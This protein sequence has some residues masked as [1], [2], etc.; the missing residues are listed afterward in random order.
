MPGSIPQSFI[1][2]LITR[3]D[4]VELIDSHVPLTKKGKE[5]MACC[6]FHNEKTPSFTVSPD[7][8][9]Y[10]CFG[11]GAHGTAVGFLMEFDRLNFVEAVEE[12]AQRAGLNVPRDTT[13]GFKD[14][15]RELST[16]LERAG[17]YYQKMLRQHRKPVEYLKARG[18]S[19]EIAT[20]FGLGFAPEGFDNLLRQ[21]RGTGTEEQLIKAGLI[22]RNDKGNCFDRFRNRIVFPIKNQRGRIIGFGGRVLDDEQPKYLN[23][24]ETPLFH[25][26]Q[27]LYGLHEARKIKESVQSMLVVEG[28]LDVLALVQYGIENV[29]ATLGTATTTSH[30]QQLY[31]YTQEIIFCFDGDRAGRDAAWRAAQHTI[32][33]FKDGCEAKF[34]FLPQGEDPDSLVRTRGKEAFLQ[35]VKEGEP[36][37]TFILDRLSEDIDMSTPAGK[38]RFAQQA[39]P[40]LEKFPQGIFKQL[41]FKELGKRVGSPIFHVATT[42]TGRKKSSDV[43]PVFTRITP[44][45]L[46]V[47]ALLRDPSLALEVNSEEE[48]KLEKADIP[49]VS[50]LAKL[51]ATWKRE[52]ELS[53]A[54]L[55]ERFRGH[56]E[57]Q[58]IQK[59]STW[60][61]PALE[62]PQ[63]AFEDAK[64][65]ILHQTRRA[66]VQELTERQSADDLSEDEKQEL[67][68]L[69]KQKEKP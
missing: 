7:K 28:Y 12:L 2:E 44:V 40:L 4:I 24:P 18:V 35:H 38:A 29:V 55:I 32:P 67:K 61:T 62:D 16:I 3:T 19:G 14:D 33:V 63:Q 51:I 21:F 27:A 69:L 64:Q 30:V 8:Q 9:F 48:A 65:K 37:F 25:K 53:Y 13:A 60:K 17:I 20:K 39:K 49:G 11:C 1:D 54:A 41:I 10:H 57:A 47:A 31:R 23:S 68:V 5:Y 52:P 15:Y 66:R 50:L 58:Q 59:L 22:K 26:S 56:Q 42:S 45:R 6:P 43:Q 46:A 36:L 34:L